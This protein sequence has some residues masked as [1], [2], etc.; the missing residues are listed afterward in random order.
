VPTPAQIEALRGELS[1]AD[2]RLRLH[3]QRVYAG[4][5]RPDPVRLAE[6]ERIAAGARE[7]LRRATAG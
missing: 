4:R 5:R 2:G 7:R 6:L 3:R 1:Y